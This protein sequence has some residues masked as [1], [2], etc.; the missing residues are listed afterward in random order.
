MVEVERRVASSLPHRTGVTRAAHAPPSPCRARSI[1]ARHRIL[2]HRARHGVCEP[3]RWPARGPCSRCEWG[4]TERRSEHPAQLRTDTDAHTDA[5]PHADPH[6][7]ADTNAR[8]DRAPI[9][10]HVL[11]PGLRP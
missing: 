10:G 3:R 7:D 4:P 6:A 1:D 5:D 8:A 9:D 2:P 11:R